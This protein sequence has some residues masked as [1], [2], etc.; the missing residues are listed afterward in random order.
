MTSLSITEVLDMKN[1]GNNGI[2]ERKRAIRQPDHGEVEM[3]PGRIRETN[4]AVT[5]VKE[6]PEA[7]AESEII[8]ESM[9]LATKRRKT[10]HGDD[11][12]KQ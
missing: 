8:S 1:E 9:E 7:E 11:D 2:I 4:E 10:E 3:V 6:R 5:Y 12:G